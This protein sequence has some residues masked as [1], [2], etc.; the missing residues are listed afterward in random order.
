MHTIC[1]LQYEHFLDFSSV[2]YKNQS[3]LVLLAIKYSD[4]VVSTL[5]FLCQVIYKVLQ[6]RKKISEKM[7]AFTEYSLTHEVKMLSN[8]FLIV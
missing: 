2:N 4:Q 1:S 5:A 3:P 6:E 8:E 7:C